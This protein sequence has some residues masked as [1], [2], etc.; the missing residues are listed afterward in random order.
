MWY[1]QKKTLMKKLIFTLALLSGPVFL[2]AQGVGVGIKAG[3]NFSN[4]SSDDYST[5]SVTKYHVGA[6][7]NINFSERFG[8]TPEV[9]WSSQGAKV[10]GVGD[11]NTNYVIVPIMLRWKPVDLI[12]IEA[13]PQFSFLTDAELDNNPNIEDQ[14]KSSTTCAAFGAGVNLPMGFIGGLRYVVGLTDLSD[15]DTVEFKDGTFQIY[16]GWTIFGAK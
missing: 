16:I 4:Y 13:G 10:K 15:N 11:F 14:L 8:V 1:I 12:F 2:F 5:S 7:V 3:A 9:L 6:Y